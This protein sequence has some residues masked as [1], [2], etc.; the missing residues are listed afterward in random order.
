MGVN[1]YAASTPNLYS[2]AASQYV[3]R[4]ATF[5]A[6]SLG[7][8]DANAGPRMFVGKLN[9]ETNEQ[10]IKV[11]SYPLHLPCRIAAALSQVDVISGIL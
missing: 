6:S 1:P 2:H 7:P 3:P 9:K 5:G 8:G 10:D 4:N 11:S